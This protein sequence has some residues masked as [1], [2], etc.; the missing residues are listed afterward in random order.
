MAHHSYYVPVTL[1]FYMVAVF[2]RIPAAF[3]G[4]ALQSAEVFV[5][6]EGQQVFREMKLPLSGNGSIGKWKIVVELTDAIVITNSEVI[7]QAD[8]K[9]IWIRK[10]RVEA[11]AYFDDTH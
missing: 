7:R 9:T 5:K 4:G 10:D 2:P 3:G 8:A 1:L 6:P 11:L